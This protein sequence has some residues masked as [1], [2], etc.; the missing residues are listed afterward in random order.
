MHKEDG[1]VRRVSSV[2]VDLR[3]LHPMP[4]LEPEAQFRYYVR[5][6]YIL[7]ATSEGSLGEVRWARRQ[8]LE[9]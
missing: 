6:A 4:R 5:Q 9:I 3:G 8:R 1:R 2:N 7:G